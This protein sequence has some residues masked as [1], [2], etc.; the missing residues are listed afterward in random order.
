MTYIYKLYFPFLPNECYI[1]RTEDLAK[2]IRDHKSDARTR[3]DRDV[4]KWIAKN[5]IDKLK[6]EV[7]LSGKNIPAIEEDNQIAMHKAKGFKL[8]NRN[9]GGVGKNKRKVG[10]FDLSGHFIG[11]FDSIALAAASV[12]KTSQQ[13]QQCCKGNLKT[14]HGFIWKYLG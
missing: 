8:L 1:G 9:S 14:A 4:S 6:C 3:L 13:L 7:L 12:G 5:G 10:K 2:R 11:E